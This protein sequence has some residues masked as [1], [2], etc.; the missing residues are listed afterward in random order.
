MSKKRPVPPPRPVTRPAAPSRP[1]AAKAAPKEQVTIPSEWRW[2][3]WIAALLGAVLYANTLNHTYVL[4]DYSIIKSNWLVQGGLKN[5]GTIFSTEYRFGSWNSPGTLY[6]PLSV[7]IFALQW[8]L[9]PDQ[10]WLGHFTNIVAYGLTGLV[11]WTTWRRILID[12]PVL[13]TALAVLFFMAHP[14][15][16]EVVANIK[17]LDEILALLFSTLALYGIWRYMDTD[18]T[19]WLV[20][21]MGLFFLGLLSK[22]GA[23][24]FILIFPLALWFFTKRDLSEVLRIGG[25]MLIPAVI[26]LI[27]R[28]KVLSS[29]VAGSKEIYSVLDNFIVEAPNK[30]SAFA[31]ACMMCGRYLYALVFPHPLVSDLGYPQYKAVTFSDWR[32]W[33]GL[34]PFAAMTIWAFANVARRHF[35]SFAILFFLLNFA[36]YSNVLFLIG[37]SFGER[38]LYTPSLGFAFMLAWGLT[39]IFKIPEDQ[40]K[41]LRAALSPAL[42]GVA[43]VILALYSFKTIQRNPDWYNSN[44]LYEADILQSPHCAKLNYHRSLEIVQK[45]MDEKTGVVFDTSW[46]RKAIASYDTTVNL[47][48]TYHDAYGSRGVAYFR[49]GDFDQA[50]RDYRRSLRHRGG[51]ATVLSNM[52]FIY[53]NKLNRP[54]SAE[55]IYRQAILYDPRFAD[56]RRN[57]GA[58]LAMQG[59]FPE[60]IKEWQ[61]GLKYE[62]KS[63]VLH[64]YI[65][66][67]YRDN[68]QPDKAQPWLDKAAALDP[69][70]KGR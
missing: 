68:H 13:M 30:L 60:A 33:A 19:S 14:V 6:R 21:A 32:A 4:D 51:N 11:L 25:L 47:Y 62:P 48:P 16:T 7:A 46:V 35:M 50:M 54:D 56:A 52:G 44:S 17:S 64:F 20:G 8:Q 2:F 23:F 49:L 58:V 65:G 27:V 24:M 31:S 45:G 26:F 29:Q 10:P 40:Q 22:E 18:K 15:H 66:S 3:G 38:L 42:M 53:L 70:Y 61:E 1:A 9:A 43:G 67:A 5:L 34:L 55:Y 57:L 59:R 41:S 39:Q 63:A 28:H 69:A 12:Q 37:T 36:L